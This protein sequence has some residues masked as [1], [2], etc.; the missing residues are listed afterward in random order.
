[1]PV[2]V[3]RSLQIEFV[4]HMDDVLEKALLVKSG[5]KLFREGTVISPVAEVSGGPENIAH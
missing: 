4:E 5:E 3:R 2:K 1:V